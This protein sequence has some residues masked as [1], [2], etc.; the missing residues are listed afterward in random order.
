M[1]PDK[2]SLEP[3]SSSGVTLQSPR[4]PVKYSELR[5]VPVEVLEEWLELV[6]DSPLP[7]AIFQLAAFFSTAAAAW[8][9]FGQWAVIG[10][11]GVAMG[12]GHL[13]YFK[14]AR[15]ACELTGVD[16]RHAIRLLKMYW[17]NSFKG[18]LQFR[19]PQLAQGLHKQIAAAEEER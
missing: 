6:I 9:F 1:N 18:G 5:D 19:R 13:E 7:M 2:S 14:R 11:S 3:T 17:A 10:I 15:R 4:L 8:Y 12:L 16:R